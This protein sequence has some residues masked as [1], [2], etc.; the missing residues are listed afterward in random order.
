[1]LNIQSQGPRVRYQMQPATAAHSSTATR[2]GSFAKKLG[3][4]KDS[5]RQTHQTEESKQKKVRKPHVKFDD[6]TDIEEQLRAM[7]PSRPASPGGLS[8]PSAT[9]IPNSPGLQ[10]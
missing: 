3:Q 8:T 10:P 9:A 2:G 1:M 7:A 4:A 6:A 5:T